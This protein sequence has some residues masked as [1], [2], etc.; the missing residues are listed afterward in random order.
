MKTQNT[1]PTPSRHIRKLPS[2]H[3]F[4]LIELIV[5]ISILTILATISFFAIK[6]YYG[7]ARDSARVTDIKT[8][9][10]GLKIAEVQM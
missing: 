3:G 5:V 9:Q 8:I 2:F 10:K 7:T 6:D 1:I 4:T